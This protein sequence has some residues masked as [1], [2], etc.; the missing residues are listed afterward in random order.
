M[1]TK[2]ALII[3]KTLFPFCSRFRINLIHLFTIIK[4][5]ARGATINNALYQWNKE[6]T[7]KELGLNVFV[8]YI[9]AKLMLI[10]PLSDDPII[11][12]GS[13]NYGSLNIAFY[14]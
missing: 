5:Q 12:S 14:C 2:N 7:T 8:P 4:Y 9:H 13:A 10:D 1:S 3:K 6:L 11:I